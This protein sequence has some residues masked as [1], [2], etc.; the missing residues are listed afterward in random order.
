MGGFVKQRVALLAV[1]M[2]SGGYAYGSGYLVRSNIVLTARH[3]LDSRAGQDLDV[4]LLGTGTGWHCASVL[5]CSTT[6]D[7]ALVVLADDVTVPVGEDPQ[8]GFLVGDSPIDVRACGF[9]WAQEQEAEGHVIRDPED[10]PGARIF[11]LTHS[12][13]HSRP[14][15]NRYHIQIGGSVPQRLAAARAWAGMSGSAVFA[16]DRLAGIVVEVPSRYGPDR[17]AALP[18]VE[19]LSDKTISSALA[20]TSLRA[21][22]SRD[23]VLQEPYRQ[24]PASLEVIG[25]S[26]TVLLQPEFAAVPFRARQEDIRILLEWADTARPVA[27]RL[28]V[29]AGGSGK[30]R[31]AAE[32]ADRLLTGGWAAGFLTDTPD[33]R[34]LSQLGSLA[35]K[36]LVI[37]DEAQ[38]RGDLASRVA[39]LLDGLGTQPDPIRVLLM[40][41]DRSAW[42]NVLRQQSPWLAGA[43]T[44]ELAGLS[45]HDRSALYEMALQTL[46][47]PRPD[48]VDISADG[49]DQPLVILLEALHQI[50]KTD[51]ARSDGRAADGVSP[52]A[53]AAGNLRDTLIDWVLVREAN[54]IWRP[55]VPSGLHADDV[56]LNRLVTI[57]A[58]ATARTEDE[59]VDRLVLLPE[60]AGAD[61]NT[62]RS[63][64]RW[65][66][67]L[68]PGQDGYLHRI[69][70]DS[71]A[72]RLCAL[73][74]PDLPELPSRLL[75]APP[76]SQAARTLGTLAH[77]EDPSVS[78]ALG[79]ALR[80]HLRR[81]ASRLID[82]AQEVGPYD[83]LGYA[84]E[85]DAALRASPVPEAAA[86]IDDL[87]P[88]GE[89]RCLA[90]AVTVAE[91]AVAHWREIGKAGTAS[92]PALAA[93]LLRLSK[94]YTAAKCPDAAVGPAEEAATR[95]RRL[96]T[97]DRNRFVPDLVRSLVQLSTLYGAGGRREEALV[98]AKEAVALGRKS[99]PGMLRVVFSKG[100]SRSGLVPLAEALG[101]LGLQYAGSGSHQKAIDPA[102]DA[103]RI[104]RQLAAHDP[105][106]WEYID[107]LIISLMNLSGDYSWCGRATEAIATAEEAVTLSRTLLTADESASNLERLA[108]ATGNAARRYF[109]SGQAQTAIVRVKEAVRLDRSLHEREPRR[110]PDHLAAE[111]Q[112][113]AQM[114]DYTRH[115]DAAVSAAEE[116]VDNYR[117]LAAADPNTYTRLL[118]IALADL[119][120]MRHMA[121][122]PESEVREAAEEAANLLRGPA[123][124]SDADA[125][126]LVPLLLDIANEHVENERYAEARDVSNEVLELFERLADPRFADYADQVVDALEA[127][128]DAYEQDGLLNEA[129]QVMKE[130]ERAKAFL[131]QDD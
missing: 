124:R 35:H 89:H 57:A 16:G 38:F 59:A 119:S 70:P 76:V 28:L 55:T 92:D 17:L 131:P 85:L 81:L 13:S 15:S 105:N 51:N 14:E 111:L 107:Q 73:T 23:D 50:H 43:D 41:R 12:L 100:R 54:R 87:L 29:G 62:Q 98:Y 21:V 18:A 118:G 115:H 122:A 121:G 27:V 58:L 36:R 3:V 65:L 101:T 77:I 97:S 7:G 78:A 42:W 52:Q 130:A 24:L 117:R 1:P 82:L 37:I 64:A 19:L 48:D 96:V 66:K 63:W 47:N 34:S 25:A 20:G 129:R 128:A 103:V 10:I 44:Q 33:E 68:L 40:A 80:K 4:W 46:G 22:W 102:Q 45:L 67:Q 90:L 109:L 5:H 93:A 49:Y 61:S 75:D 116:A 112:S 126:L 30:T 123:E 110:S 60:L 2:A 74:I 53:H 106:K 9:P 108:S 114:L 72:E 32:V 88:Y 79:N 127:V 56:L 125:A 69:R 84:A 39:K 86:D 8:F 104:Y 11:P 26:Q 71:I 6:I 95:F 113:L 31:L 83:D 94:R 91:Q 120:G 99:S